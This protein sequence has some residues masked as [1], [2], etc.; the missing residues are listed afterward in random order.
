MLA[1]AKKYVG[2]AVGIGAGYV[3]LA[4]PPA[5]LSSLGDPMRLL[6]GAITALVLMLA[7]NNLIA[8]SIPD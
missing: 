1:N 3:A 4:G 2:A 6:S 8:P 5:V 7:W